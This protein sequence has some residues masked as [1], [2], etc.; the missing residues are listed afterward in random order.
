M[1]TLILLIC[2]TGFFCLYNT[3]RR[4]KLVSGGTIEFWLQS[5]QRFAKLLGVTGI[6]SSMAGLIFLDGTVMGAL[7]GLLMI[8]AAGCY[9]V[10]LAPFRVIRFSHILGLGVIAFVMEFLIF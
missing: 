4:A 1:Y 5:N 7:H 9:I 10:S 2:W 6:F 8:M 3:S